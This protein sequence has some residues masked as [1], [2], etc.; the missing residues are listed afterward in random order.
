[1]KNIY[2]FT[3]QLKVTYLVRNMSL[4]N[5][6]FIFKYYMTLNKPLLILSIVFVII[7]LLPD[8]LVYILKKKTAFI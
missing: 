8:I 4:F 1:M 2:I 7:L 6:Y 5:K 3:V